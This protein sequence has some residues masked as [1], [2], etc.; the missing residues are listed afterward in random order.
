MMQQLISYIAPGAPATRQTATGNEPYLRPEIGFTPKWYRDALGIDFSECWH[1][2]VEYRLESLSRMRTELDRRFPGARIGLPPNHGQ[3]DLLTGVHGACVIAGIYGCPIVYREDQWPV[4]VGAP[5]SDSQV[6]ELLSPNLEVNPFFQSLMMQVDHIA[7]RLGTVT[8]YIN[9]QGVLN[10]AH[11]LR[12]E[13]LF[14]DLL[15][16]PDLCHHLF[17]CVCTTMIEAARRLHAR[18]RETG[19]DVSFFTVSNCLVNLVS[20]DIYRE[21]L[22]PYDRRIADTF[23]TIGVHNCAWTVDPYLEDYASLPNLA[24]VDMGLESDLCTAQKLMP[25]A[26]RAVMYR[27]TELADKSLEEIEF[28]LSRICQELGPCDI[29][30]ADIESG[31]PDERVIAFICICQELSDSAIKMTEKR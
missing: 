31:T 2:D 28:D 19:F 30:A 21:F 26:R 12:G 14:T 15:T 18:Q 9:W 4:A 10:N 13:E 22:L 16:A 5:L 11:R 25:H 27:P 20:P 17:E 24:Y 1:T 7:D 8:G 3:I 6:L 23:A 29:V